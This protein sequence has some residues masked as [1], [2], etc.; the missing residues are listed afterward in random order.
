ME[1]FKNSSLAHLLA[2]SGAHTGYLVLGITYLL[3]GSRIS[4][5]KI[6]III[7]LTLFLF[8]AVTGFSPSVVRAGVM[9]IIL[10]SSKLFHRKQD[11]WTAISFT[12]LLT[13]VNNPFSINN[14][15][16]QLSYIGTIGII[17]LNKNIEY[18]IS[19]TKINSKLA[20]GLSVTF[21][22]QISLMPIIVY[23]FG[24][25]SFTFFISNI[26]A[27]PLLG[28]IILLGFSTIGVS[29]IFAEVGNVIALVLNLFLE[30]LEFVAE[31]V[32][33][34]PLSNVIVTTPKLITIILYYI[35]LLVI[36]YIYGIYR[37]RRKDRRIYIKINN[38]IERTNKKD[39]IKVLAMLLLTLLIFNIVYVN[40]PKDLKIYF[41]DVG[42]RRFY[43]NCYTK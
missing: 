8:M 6:N 34:L 36:N 10:L 17:L 37:H 5:R 3:N 30:I 39:A 1:N 19:K 24:I 40:I 42:Q 43:I 31:F 28:I 9:G 29:F 38:T 26:L 27:M 22:A 13:M 20:K 21:A 14:I 2:V 16:L 35:I 23:N 4:K 18:I 32:A 11:T 15:G 33:K 12:L 7:I 25:F 41:I